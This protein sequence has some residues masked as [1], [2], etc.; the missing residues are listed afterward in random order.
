MPTTALNLT[1][2]DFDHALW[3]RAS[4]SSSTG[5]DGH[6]IMTAMSIYKSEWKLAELKLDA[7]RIRRINQFHGELVAALAG[8]REVAS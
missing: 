6:R 3:H 7:E 8:K 1:Q 5:S 2:P 4:F